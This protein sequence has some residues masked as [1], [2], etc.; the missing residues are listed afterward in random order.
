MQST[1]TDFLMVGFIFLGSILFCLV[2]WYCC[3]PP[4]DAKEKSTAQQTVAGLVDKRR[5]EQREAAQRKQFKPVTPHR[6]STPIT[7]A[8]TEDSGESHPA[9]VK[10]LRGGEFI[11]NRM[12]FKVKVLNESKFTITDVTVWLVS[13]PG[14]AM[15]LKDD[16]D[17][18][19]PKIEPGG[20]RSPHFD[21][22][23]TQDCVRGEIV[24]GVSYVDASGHAHSLT[25]APF[26]IRS[27]CDLLQPEMIDESEFSRRLKELEC[28][29]LTVKVGE[30]TP[31]EMYEKTLR[32]L[33]QSNF[34][35]VVSSI[36]ARDG[37]TAGEVSGWAKG[38]YTGKRLGV[39]IRIT[40][41]SG[42][43]GASCRITMSGED[44]AMILPA[45]DDLKE[46]LSAWLCPFCGSKLT[47]DSVE[48][49][50]AGHSIKCPF[51]SVTVGR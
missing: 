4:N 24:A 47:L 21:L 32:I 18:R 29:E 30:W 36:D 1:F 27:V 12:R 48:D 25:T 39:R 51:C 33:G 11:G 23:P 17:I 15:R 41:K 26:T 43:A 34:Y 7:P 49:L 6:R 13:Y 22:L 50:K 46:Q 20:F 5:Q 37:V 8:G 42:R 2:G 35:E 45:I 40:G 28:G 9:Q 10:A 14:E 31:E 16:D 19:F 44:D 38:K 3:T